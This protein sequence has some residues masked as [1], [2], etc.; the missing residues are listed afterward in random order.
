MRMTR[1]GFG[2][3]VGG[4]VVA[5]G[6]V[7]SWPALGEATLS[8]ALVDIEDRSGLARRVAPVRLGGVLAETVPDWD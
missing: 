7:R 1:R 6:L 4:A 2:V 8:G 3:L 5:E